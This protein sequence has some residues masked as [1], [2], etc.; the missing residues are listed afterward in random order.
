[1]AII[2]LIAVPIILDVV[3]DARISAGK[4]EANM[5]LSSINNYCA[6]EDVKYQLDNSY[7]RKCTT[8]L[9]VDKVKEMVN[10]GN[11]DIIN[12]NY[13]GTKLTELVIES[14]NH[15]FTLCPSGQFA[16]DDEECDAVAI[17]TT[18][19]IKDVVLSNFP[20]LATN[21]NGCL[22]SNNYNY[23][24]MGGCY[25]SGDIDNF[26]NGKEIFL[27][28]NFYMTKSDISK[29]F[30]AENGSF[31]SQEYED[32]RRNIEKEHGATDEEINEM[33]QDQGVD[34]FL[35]YDFMMSNEKI[36]ELIQKDGIELIKLMLNLRFGLT[37]EEIANNFFDESGSFKSQEYEDYRRKIE[38]DYGRTDEEINEMFQNLGVGTFFELDFGT[39]S[40]EISKITGKEFLINI[41]FNRCL[42]I[43]QNQIEELFFDDKGNFKSQEYENY[44]METVEI[45]GMT[46]E[47]IDEVINQEG[48]NKFFE[49][50]F[51]M[52]PELFFK[53][54]PLNN[55]I[56]YSGFLWRIMG[57][58]ADGTVR[59]ITDEN[60]T[61]I[62]WNNLYQAD[63]WEESYVKDWLNNY[64][65]PQLKGNDIIKEQ[66]W[67]SEKSSYLAGE[68]SCSNNLAE[69][70]LKVGLITTAEYMLAGFNE[71]YLNI[72]E[73]Q[74]TMT[75]YSSNDVWSINY[76][77]LAAYYSPNEMYGIRPIIN[78]SEDAI[79]TSGNG[80]IGEIW[81]NEAGPY[82]LSENKTVEVVG[83]LSENAT[84]GEYV[85]FA[86]KKYRVVNKDN[87]GNTK[88]ILDGYYEENGNIYEMEYGT[89]DM[90]STTTG[91]GKKLNSDILNWLVSSSD[92]KNRDKLVTDYLWYQNEMGYDYKDSLEENNPINSVNACVGLIR[93][94][95]LLSSQS[96]SILTKGYT[97]ASNYS[98]ANE[99][100]TMTPDTANHIYIIT[101]NGS[102]SYNMLRFSSN[103]RPVI[104]IK[105]DVEI[106]S[107]TGTFSNPY[108]I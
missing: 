46:V 63:D 30:F 64:F 79:I 103:I 44:A 60:V 71:S 88:L 78:I 99:Y 35:E 21:G 47:E 81:S 28:H 1:M 86:G 10:L 87:D 100:W 6:T 9:D 34:T 76:S 61:A 92:T 39:K 36:N 33:L 11:A 41:M 62:A 15:T 24:Y 101:D 31:K 25:L 32:Y 75:P 56:W 14:N 94:G 70:K 80:T 65:Y 55:Y 48:E 50:N 20:Y 54:Y 3:E 67:C 82:I 98:N 8:S 108:V 90:F 105:S 19:P 107:G 52:T 49:F 77:G 13:D 89:D 102:S 51:G 73:F 93:V 40:E 68:S 84:N 22:T 23:S 66:V 58:N 96:S 29:N 83:K 4:S 104:V 27:N 53:I 97:T 45:S 85:V 72:E 69:Q 18:G 43:S 91:I 2:A 57:I 95:E 5:I 26:F 74:W 106:I 38:K 17:I 42:L 59:L 16:M 7:V 37:E 12:V